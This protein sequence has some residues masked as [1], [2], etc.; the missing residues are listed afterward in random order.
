MMFSMTY[1]AIQFV[2]S[3]YERKI[4]I[5]FYEVISLSPRLLMNLFDLINVGWLR[6][7]VTDTCQ[8]LLELPSSLV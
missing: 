5:Y 6:S 3:D 4:N 8:W 7:S 2:S 1:V